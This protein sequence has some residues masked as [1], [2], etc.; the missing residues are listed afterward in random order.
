VIDLTDGAPLISSEMTVFIR[1]CVSGT[2]ETPAV[3]SGAEFH[4]DPDGDGRI[5]QFRPAGP[6][7]IVAPGDTGFAFMKIS[8]R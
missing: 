7:F 8:D 3:V 2:A 4:Y 5:S 1:V 6:S